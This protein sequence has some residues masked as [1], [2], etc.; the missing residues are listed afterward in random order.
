[1]RLLAMPKFYLMKKEHKPQYIITVR[2]VISEGITYKLDE[3]L[4]NNI[5]EMLEQLMETH[6]ETTKAS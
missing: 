3:M 1:M 6:C 5:E 2:E 4:G